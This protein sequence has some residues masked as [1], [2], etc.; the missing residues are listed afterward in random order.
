MSALFSL[1]IDLG[2]SNSAVAV[3]DFEHDRAAVV[4]IT[5]LM[6][7]NQIGE[8]STLA[9]ALYLPHPDEFPG[10]ALRLPW[11]ETG[12]GP[13]VGHFARVHGALIPDRLITSAKSWLSNFHIDPKKAVLPWKSTI[14]EP[15]LSA[16][17]CSR[18]YLEHIREGFLAAERGQGRMWNFADGEIVLTVPA[19]FDEVARNFT[20]EAAEAAGLG[21]VVLL[22][23]PQAA[24]YAW[25]AQAGSN[26][27][28]QVR[29]GDIVL[30]CDVGG[31]TADFSLLAI[32]ETDGRLEVERV[33]VG[34][35]LLLG[36]DNMD[37]ALAY[38]L[39]A[40]LD[41]AGK[42]IDSWQF[43]AL[44]HAAR[45]A[46]VSLFTDA[47]LAQAPIAVPS[48]GSKLLARTVS[49]AL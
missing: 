19:S 5:Q 8:M 24:F 22:E 1:G 26:W 41:A 38:T 3:E 9:S 30:V 47:S 37:L 15:K 17:E 2:T 43:L 4:E 16:F 10:N 46:K 14:Q 18:R 20:A 13:I 33:S 28:S 36:G 23:E 29:P 27:R 40:Q 21:K 49:T 48:R 42:T 31:G 39:Q 25:T 12:G 44:I 45:E 32:T 35:H 11:S 34:E 7:P 6:G